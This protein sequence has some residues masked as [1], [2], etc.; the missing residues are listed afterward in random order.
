MFKPGMTSPMRTARRRAAYNP[1]S[2][3]ALALLTLVWAGMVIGVSGLAT[4]AKFYAPSLSLPVA[5]DVGRTTFHVFTRVE[6]ILGL[7]LV[8]LLHALR[9]RRLI[10]LGALLVVSILLVQALY[11]LPELDLRVAAIIAGQTPPPSS[12]H[13]WYAAAEAGKLAALFALGLAG[14]RAREQKG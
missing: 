14:L 3:M 2:S 4:P 7:A 6:W 8:L 11:L 9:H 10:L 1:L 5:L 13:T 12:L